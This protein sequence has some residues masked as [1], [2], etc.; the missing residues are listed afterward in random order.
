MSDL[1]NDRTRRQSRPR[2]RRKN[3]STKT[4]GVGAAKAGSLSPEPQLDLT[5]EED[6][7]PNPFA[8]DAAVSSSLESI[9]VPPRTPRSGRNMDSME[10]EVEMSLL[11]EDERKAAATDFDLTNGESGQR[12]AKGVPPMSSKDKKAVALLIVLCT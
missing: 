8:R 3:P 5:G 2:Q 11:T 1:D 4:A 10:E 9:H 6:K 12:S 7:M